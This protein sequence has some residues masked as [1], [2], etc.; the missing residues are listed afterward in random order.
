M[1]EGILLRF[2]RQQASAEAIIRKEVVS[3][4]FRREEKCSGALAK[5]SYAVA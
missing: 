3:S 4:L 5:S 1:V 2:F